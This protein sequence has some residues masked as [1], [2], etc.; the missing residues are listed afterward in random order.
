MEPAE[1]RT[2]NEALD[3]LWARFLPVMEE[4]V[5]ALEAAARALAEG[6]LSVGQRS[7]ANVAAHKLAGVLGTF[8]L[9][10]GTV[11]A[12][13]AEIIYSGEPDTD[14]AAAEQLS[15][16]ARQLKQMVAEHK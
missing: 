7:A 11:L 9:T 6:T 13:E 2:L 3:G 15:D 16:I 12:R 4:R 8:G 14:P 5:A 1:E 10:R